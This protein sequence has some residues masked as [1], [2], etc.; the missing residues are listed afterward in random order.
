MNHD[1]L[2]FVANH[3]WQSTVF[4]A[5][6]GLLTLALR[7]SRARIRHCIWLTASCKFLV[8]FSVFVAIG[9]QVA[10][11]APSPR[12]QSTLSLV[13]VEFSQPFAAST[14]SAPASAPTLPVQRLVP[15]VLLIVWGCGIAGIAFSWWIR[16]R[17]ILAMVR[18]AAPLQLA[19][20]VPARSSPTALEPGVF[21]VFKPTLLLPAGVVDRL[22]ST[23]LQAVITHELCHIRYRDNLTAAIQMFVETVFWFHP[24]VWWI[25]KRMVEERERACDEE[26]LRLGNEPR[27]YAEGI[28]NICKHYV[29]APLPCISAVTGSDLKKR[30]DSII[31]GNIG[32]ELSPRQ[33]I[34][35]AAVGLIAIASPITIGMLD[36]LAL[37][38]QQTEPVAP[39]AFEVASVKANNNTTERN[40]AF[41]F[42]PGRDRL[43]IRNFPLAAILFRAYNVPRNRLTLSSPL[44]SQRY[45]ID[46]KTGH[47]VGRREMLRM[48]QTLLVERFKISLH[49]ETKEVSGYALGLADGGQKF[50]EHA[51]EAAGDCA[52]RIQSDGQYVFEN[53]SMPFFAMVLTD[54]LNGVDVIDKTGLD[55]SYDF[56]LKASWEL[57]NPPNPTESDRP[58]EVN[59]GAPSIFAALPRQLGLKLDRQRLPVEFLVID[60][61]EK[62]SDN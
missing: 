17:R 51:G 28:L 5:V 8:P 53:C 4:A 40:W 18:D 47:P 21:G 11:R 1:F 31:R 25:G 55:K 29:G 20:P 22:T 23:Q 24:L 58:R 46:A 50:S 9:G 7:N 44:A 6:A 59:P 62:P 3:L 10:R 54:I 48:L 13:A 19:I 32:H 49:R 14:V 60:H 42:I 37:S 30:I 35:L 45:D 16:W 34:L 26:V 41:E 33:V 61:V 2:R 27:V 43:V 52:G 15:S 57:P 56:R 12:S 38:A 39:A 36:P